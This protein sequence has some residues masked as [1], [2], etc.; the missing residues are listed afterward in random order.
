M[1]RNYRQEIVE[2]KN[3][4]GFTTTYGYRMRLDKLDII[5]D[6]VLDDDLIYSEEL[7]KYVYVAIVA[8]LEGFFRSSIS[9]LID[10]G[11]PYSSNASQFNQTK[12]IKFDFD[13]ITALQNK[14]VTGG[15][16]VAH[17][18]PCSQLNHLNSGLSTVIGNDF[19][20][21]LKTYSK[22]SIYEAVKT[23]NEEFNSRSSEVLAD[24][25]KVFELRH[26]IVHEFAYDVHLEPESTMS[27]Y[28][29]CK[30]FLAQ[31]DLMVRDLLFPDEPETQ[32]EINLKAIEEFNVR[33]RELNELCAKIKDGKA[34]G[35]SLVN[36]SLFD[37]VLSKWRAYR[38]SESKL[39]ASG[40]EGGTMYTGFY[41]GSKSSIT[42]DFTKRLNRKYL[43][44]I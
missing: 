33:E 22:S 38:E 37:D 27:I 13:I 1:K 41:A 24:V 20:E 34:E 6:Q 3:R 10:K 32:T 23:T 29:N 12:S 42:A 28:R 5:L 15:E 11:M 30:L 17:L 39:D 8:C 7:L 44:H 26:V 9:K 36:I 21:S 2:I 40:F 43:K 25:T 19:L 18:L 16:L 31:A 4:G 35:D 14:S